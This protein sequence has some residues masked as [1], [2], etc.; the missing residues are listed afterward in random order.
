MGG[1]RFCLRE[2]ARLI[3]EKDLSGVP[4]KRHVLIWFFTSFLSITIVVDGG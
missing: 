4:S 1:G 2:I 3:R